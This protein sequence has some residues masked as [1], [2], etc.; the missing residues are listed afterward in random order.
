VV[1]NFK[2]HLL[3]MLNR[4]DVEIP[5]GMFWQLTPEEAGIV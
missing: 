3:E 1:L 2:A 4:P 5:N